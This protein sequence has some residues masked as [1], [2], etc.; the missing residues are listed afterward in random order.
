M[1]RT[2]TMAGRIVGIV[3]GACLLA[4]PALAATDYSTMSNEELAAMRGTMR[5]AAPAERDS[6]R[7]E[8][9]NRVNTMSQAERQTAVGRPENAPRDGAGYRYGQGSG[10]GSG[11][12]TRKGCRQK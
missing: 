3:L 2:T 12:G 8:W 5:D 1:K 11:R 10:N 6:F 7:A 9:Q 4:L